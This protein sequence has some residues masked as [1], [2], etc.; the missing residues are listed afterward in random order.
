MNNEKQIVKDVIELMHDLAIEE[1]DKFV[2]KYGRNPGPMEAQ[3]IA[4]MIQRQAKT[5]LIMVR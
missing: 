3:K 1:H 5:A 2:E 4:E